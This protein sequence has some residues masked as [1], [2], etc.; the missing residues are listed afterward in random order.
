M[1]GLIP[2]HTQRMPLPG[3]Q[4]TQAQPGSARAVELRV[5]NECPDL[6]RVLFHVVVPP[7]APVSAVGNRF[8]V[9]LLDDE[10]T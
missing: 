5:A 10:P 4:A 8:Q 9:S 7:D 3:G 6:E 1:L 2:S